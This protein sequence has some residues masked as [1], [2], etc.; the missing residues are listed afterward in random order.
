MNIIT[1][2]DVIRLW[3]S[4]GACKLCTIC[5]IDDNSQEWKKYF[6]IRYNTD[7]IQMMWIIGVSYSTD[8]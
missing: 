8:T 2:Y 3:Y 6:G 1:T 7:N 5:F 4:V